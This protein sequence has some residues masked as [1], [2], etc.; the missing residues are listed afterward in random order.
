MCHDDLEKQ[1]QIHEAVTELKGEFNY[2]TIRGE[3]F[4][5]HNPRVLEQ[6]GGKSTRKQTT[7]TAL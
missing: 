1:S 3:D 2:S 5:T 7:W 6:L 4:N